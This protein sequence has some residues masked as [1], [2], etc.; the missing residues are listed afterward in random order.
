M[1]HKKKVFTTRIHPLYHYFLVPATV[2]MIPILAVLAMV[3]M[4]D[5]LTGMLLIATYVF[6]HLGIYITREYAKR[7]QDRIIRSE[8]R[9]RFFVLGGKPL[10]QQESRLSL[11]QLIV[12]RFANDEQLPEL[13]SETIKHGWLPQVIKQ[14][15]INGVPDQ[16]RV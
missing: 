12:L 2:L 15:I 1:E 11:A 5:M 16:M 13:V 4:L 3:G 14:Q 6:L 10:L 7:N 8:L 9:L